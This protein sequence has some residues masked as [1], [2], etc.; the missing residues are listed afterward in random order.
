MAFV[1]LLKDLMKDKEHRPA[2]RADHPGRGPHLRHGLA[3]PDRED[4]LAARAEL[5]PVDRELMLS[6]KEADDR[7]D[8][9]RGHQRGRLDRRRSPPPARR[10]PRTA[11]R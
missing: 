5:H 2:V 11:S 6:Y 8:P 9:A 10:T 1:R 3:V 4:L 7:A